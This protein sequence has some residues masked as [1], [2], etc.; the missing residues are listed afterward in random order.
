M[1]D[2]SKDAR[3]TSIRPAIEELERAFRAF[4]PLFGRE[5]PL[6]VITIQTTGRA[7]AYGWFHPA[8]WQGS[9]GGD[10]PEIN[11]CA[12][13]LSRGVEEIAETLIHEMSHFVNALEGVT[14]CNREQYHNKAF[15]DRAES[16]GLVVAKM[17]RHGWAN[18]TLSPELRARVADLRLDPE[19]FALFRRR[20][21]RTAAVSRMRKWTCACPVIVRCAVELCATCDECGEP[22]A[23]AE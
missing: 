13:H 11:I 9:D 18:T 19:A 16:V 1:Q 14:D 6:P 8:M 17:G 10:L 15:K 7:S 2:M 4:A 23:R 5:L 12:E 3:D 20:Q 22:F 21:A